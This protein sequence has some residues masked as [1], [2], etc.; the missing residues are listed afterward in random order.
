ME[1]KLVAI[2]APFF[3]TDHRAIR[4]TGWPI[5][6]D[7]RDSTAARKPSG[8]QVVPPR[9]AAP[10]AARPEKSLFEPL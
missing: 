1:S 8:G 6:P 3:V 4:G 10:R 7:Q 5:G 9:D 2:T